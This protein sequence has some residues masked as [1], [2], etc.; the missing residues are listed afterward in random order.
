M[1]GKV[2]YRIKDIVR[3]DN[4]G[5]LYF[6]DRSVDMIKHKGYRIAVTEIERILP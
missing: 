5:W 4:E 6:M 1:D 2:W 3:I